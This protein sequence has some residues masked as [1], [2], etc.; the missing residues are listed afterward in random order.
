VYLRRKRSG[1]GPNA[2]IY[3]QLVESV[4][5][6]DRV[7]Q[8][9]IAS[10][11]REDELIGSG[12][13]D[14]LVRNIARHSETLRVYSLRD[15]PEFGRCSTREWGP[16]LVFG[17]LWEQQGLP[18]LIRSLTAS[19][20]Y[21]F[22]MERAIFA[23]ALQRVSDPGSDRQGALW[24][25]DVECPG[26]AAL[27]LQHLYRAVGFLE[28]VRS[29]LELNL[30]YKDRGLFDCEL[31]LVFLDTTSTYVYRDEETELRRR[32]Y[33]RD[34]R[35]DLPQ[36]VL[37][38]AVDPTGWPIAWEVLP[39]NTTDVQAM[40]KL[41]E[42]FRE[43]FKIRAIT[44]VADRGMMSADTLRLLEDD[45]KAP[46]SYILGC[47]MRRQTVVRDDVLARAGRYHVCSENLQV[48]EVYADSR[49]YV[50]CYNPEEA[51]RDAAARQAI[52]AKL[53]EA[54]AGD[55][56]KAL[57]K[58]RGYARYLKERRNSF[59]LDPQAIQADKRYDGK[60]VLMTNTPLSTPEV[61]QAYKQLWRVERIFRE[62]KTTLQV[63]PL[64]HQTDSQVTGHLEGAFLALRLEVDLA[65]RMADRNTI[66]A[67]PDLIRDL[68]N[69]RVV[70]LEVDGQ[71]YRV[72][73]DILGHA[74]AAFQAAGVKPPPK[75]VAK[76]EL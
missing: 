25:R 59:T 21:V 75:A 14:A 30:F 15:G 17:R 44:V 22:D 42:R 56:A 7:Q 41:I 26:F 48:K 60:Y 68:K 36:V 46:F 72:R 64:Y 9:L 45:E 37:C 10:L 58:N 23:L 69:V 32:G 13:L 55:G 61:A 39:G 63:R 51:E 16:A 24:L 57:I 35:P 34:K 29:S 47:R 12:K 70:D 8:R 66:C 73:T 53:E 31:D 6:G 20:R 11:G 49:R 5:S 33:S 19:R 76:G 54:P 62:T 2:H 52:V 38:V 27:E 40:Q 71:P 43:K 1:Q 4:R 74:L 3:L 28:E 67:W 65:R 50:V 18:G